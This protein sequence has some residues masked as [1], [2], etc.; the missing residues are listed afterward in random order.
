MTNKYMNNLK[1]RLKSAFNF[2]SNSSG[3]KNVDLPPRDYILNFNIEGISEHALQ[4]AK[5]IRKAQRKPAIIIHGVMPR[6]GTVYVGELLR[7][8]PDIY[9]YPNDVWE[10]PF[11]QFLN[12]I[13]DFQ[14]DFFQAYKQN[15]SKIGQ[16]DFL[17]LFG[18]AFIDYL[19]SS[20]PQG[21]R[22]LLKVPNVQ[23]LN[24]FFSVFP[25]ENLLLLMRDGRDLVSSTLSTWPD[26]KFVNVCQQWNNSTQMALSFDAHYCTHRDDYLLVKY[27]TVINDPV[28]FVKKACAR[29]GLDSTKFP[30]EKIEQLPIRG[31]SKIKQE[32]KTTWDPIEKP[33]NYQS[34]QRWLNW[35]NEEKQ[36]FKEIAG[37]TLIDAYYEN[38]L[39]W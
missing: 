36:T 5:T 14:N 25:Y 27:E 1:K 31:S 4:S 38:N 12:N 35:S 18:S 30:F 23:Y 15:I 9:A 11:L 8:H 10:I 26:K 3:N 39:D 29:F 37:Q 34:T 21:K 16:N 32:G 17:P 6:S 33:K 19:Y 13:I 2:K 7:L 28:D 20:V 22:M 24:Y